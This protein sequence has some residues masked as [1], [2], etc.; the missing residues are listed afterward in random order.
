LDQGQKMKARR[1]DSGGGLASASL[2]EL[3]RE[4]LIRVGE[5]PRREGL[6]RTPER[7]KRS[8]EFLTKGCQEDP[9]A[10]LRGALFRV[11]YD[12][13]VMVKDIEMFSLCEHH[14][15]PFFGKVHVA[16]IPKGKVIGLSKIPRLVDCFARR[17]QVQERLTTQIAEAIRTAIRPL[18]VGVVIEARHLCMMMRGV[19]KQHSA[20]VTS[21][22]LGAFRSSKRTRDEFLSLIH[23]RANGSLI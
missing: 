1:N 18:G 8:F 5:D 12:E 3:V 15:L 21:A 9:Q 10:I 20:A 7:V 17:L 6:L 13:M 4:V 16:Y 22:M 19:E 11:S 2:E 14:L 23:G